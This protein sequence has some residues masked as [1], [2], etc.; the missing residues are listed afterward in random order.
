MARTTK[1]KIV[2]EPKETTSIPQTS[3]LEKEVPSIPTCETCRFYTA[4]ER[5]G[6]NM[7]VC[8]RYPVHTDTP[9]TQWCGEH[10]PK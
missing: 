4:F 7:K 5:V 6:L 10:Q 8:R 3:G 9:L 1:K 2:G